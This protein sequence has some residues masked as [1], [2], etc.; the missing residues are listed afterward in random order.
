MWSGLGQRYQKIEKSAYRVVIASGKFIHYFQS[1]SITVKINFPIRQV[2]SKLDLAGR[3]VVWS[4]KLS[5][6]DI[7]YEPR[8][9]IKAQA[10]D[11]FF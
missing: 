4:V 2:L 6:Y 8:G 3:M 7:N 10:M 9:S 11:N 1:H 5:E